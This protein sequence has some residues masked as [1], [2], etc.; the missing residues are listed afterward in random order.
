MSCLEMQVAVLDQRFQELQSSE[1]ASWTFYLSL[2]PL[3][4]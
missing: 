3:K 1:K 4:Y 2:F